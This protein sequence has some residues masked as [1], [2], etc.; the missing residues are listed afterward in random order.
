MTGQGCLSVY[1]LRSLTRRSGSHR[2]ACVNIGC[3]RIVPGCYLK[4]GGS[5]ATR[6]KHVRLVGKLAGN[7]RMFLGIKD[8]DL[9]PSGL[10]E[11]CCWNNVLGS[12]GKALLLP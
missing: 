9:D 12:F 3:V 6:P 5:W 11:G 10:M 8:T 2:T 4:L 7:T 1:T